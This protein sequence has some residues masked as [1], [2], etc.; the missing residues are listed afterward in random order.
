VIGALVC[1]ATSGAVQ[2]EPSTAGLPAAGPT[3]YIED[4]ER[5]HKIYDDA[6]L[7]ADSRV[8]P[9]TAYRHEKSRANQVASRL[10]RVMLRVLMGVVQAPSAMPDLQVVTSA[11]WT[12]CSIS[13]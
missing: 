5:F 3:I 1:A 2:K 4:V 12:D 13:P 7:S 11:S 9:C 8:A 10:A 6:V